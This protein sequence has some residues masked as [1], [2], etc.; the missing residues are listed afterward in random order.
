MSPAPGSRHES[1]RAFYDRISGAYDLIADASERAARRAGLDL[2]AVQPGERVLE[3]GFGT[4]NEIL[5]LAAK[6]GPAGAVCGVDISLG[7]LAVTQRKLRES[8][9]AARIDLRVADARQLPFNA[10][11]FDAAYGSF[12]LELFT[13]DDIPVVLSELRRVLRPGGR[14]GVVAMAKASADQPPTALQ[15]AYDWMHRQFPHFVDCRPIDAT[16]LLSANGFRVNKTLEMEIWTLPVTAV[17]AN[18]P[19]LRAV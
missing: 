15:R 18:T 12:T 2:L 3:I 17:V 13:D 5:D 6:V 19:P 10:A 1:N 4:G 7:M 8:K 16:T 14:L 9:P 11:A